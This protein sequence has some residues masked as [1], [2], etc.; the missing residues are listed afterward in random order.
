LEIVKLFPNLKDK[1][2]SVMKGR[3]VLELQQS[4]INR[5]VRRSFRQRKYNKTMSKPGKK[6]I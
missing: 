3:N 2:P 4:T 6:I 5:I 1:I